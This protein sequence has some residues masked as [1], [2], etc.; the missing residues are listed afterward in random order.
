MT[1]KRSWTIVFA[2]ATLLTAGFW[3]LKTPTEISTPALII[4]GGLDGTLVLGAYFLDLG[5]VTK[6]GLGIMGVLAILAAVFLP[7]SAL[8]GALALINLIMLM[9]TAWPL[10]KRFVTLLNIPIL[11][12]AAGLI[13]ALAGIPG[14]WPWIIVLAIGAAAIFAMIWVAGMEPSDFKMEPKTP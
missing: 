6:A 13:A 5:Q 9:L 3:L 2:A 14:I 7:D 1:L 8:I 10:D 12:A 11:I 4:I